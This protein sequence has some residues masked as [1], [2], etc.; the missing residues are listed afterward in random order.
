MNF[1]ISG[2]SWFVLAAL[3]LLLRIWPGSHSWTVLL[4]TG[5]GGVGKSTM[6]RHVLECIPWIF[7]IPL[8]TTRAARGEDTSPFS[9]KRPIPEAAFRRRERSKLYLHF[10]T[11]SGRYGFSLLTVARELLRT[12]T[13]LVTVGDRPLIRRIKRFAESCGFRAV[14][15]G[16]VRDK[17]LRR[18]TLRAAGV[19]D[20][21][22]EERLGRDEERFTPAHLAEV[23][24]VIV[25]NNGSVDEF[26]GRFLRAATRYIRRDA[27]IPLQV[28]TTT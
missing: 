16:V 28:E 7:G 5:S 13:V 3:Y 19:A 24:D 22:I 26:I 20:A 18:S 14:C 2:L 4:M 15:I 8:D 11:K 1:I 23:C 17:E 21:Q 6:H 9:D 10:E 25:T 12:G 27:P